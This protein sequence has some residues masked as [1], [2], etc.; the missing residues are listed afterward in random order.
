MS[1]VKLSLQK[2]THLLTEDSQQVY[3][4]LRS[5]LKNAI[6]QKKLYLEAS[7]K[8]FDF[9]HILSW[10]IQL[11]CMAMQESTP[12]EEMLAN[13]S[14]ALVSYVF[15]QHFG[16]RQPTEQPKTTNI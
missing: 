4:R 16:Q 3:Q 5:L 7:I 6:F 15:G 1:Q 10:K 9:F 14:E 8:V 2:L 12:G 13:P 11:L